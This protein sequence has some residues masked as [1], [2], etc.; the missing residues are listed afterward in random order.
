MLGCK[1]CE[2]VRDSLGGVAGMYMLKTRHT[3]GEEKQQSLTPI[4]QLNSLVA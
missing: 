2:A 1:A 4:E 3:A